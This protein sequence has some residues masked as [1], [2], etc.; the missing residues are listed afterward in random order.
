MCM[1]SPAAAGVACCLHARMYQLP[2][3]SFAHHLLQLLHPCLYAL[4]AVHISDVIYQ[5]SC[6]GISVVDGAQSM[7]AFLPS[8]VPDGQLH[9]WKRFS[10]ALFEPKHFERFESMQTERHEH[11]RIYALVKHTQQDCRFFVEQKCTCCPQA[12][13]CLVRKAACRV[14]C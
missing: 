14:A 4:E 13:I 5:Q 6:L 9:L 10:Q 11:H 3:L 8:S 12:L 2:V 1:Y 7:K